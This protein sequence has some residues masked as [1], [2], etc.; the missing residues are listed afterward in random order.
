MG[1]LDN[2]ALQIIVSQRAGAAIDYDLY[3]ARTARQLYNQARLV[4]ALRSL[5]M[6][7]TRKPNRLCALSE[8]TQHATHGN[9]HYAGI[10]AVPL[11]QIRG[12][13]NRLNDFDASFYPLRRHNQGRWLSVATARLRGA[14][15][16]LVDL[17][18][19][20]DIYYVRDGHHR[21]SVARAMGEEVIDAEVLVWGT[22]CAIADLNPPAGC[23]ITPR[24]LQE[25]V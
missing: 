10:R 7:L 22:A 23:R 1:D 8:V 3:I 6:S 20:G 15:L 4:A 12:S 17:I 24:P 21:L 13:E 25:P 2:Y 16:P 9:G 18:Q 14:A 5:W 19:V 11:A